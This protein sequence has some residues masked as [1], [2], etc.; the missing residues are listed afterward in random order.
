MTEYGLH[1]SLW[2][3]IR[4]F[5]SGMVEIPI[6]DCKGVVLG[7]GIVSRYMSTIFLDD[8]INFKE[9]SL[10]RLMGSTK[11]VFISP[12]LNLISY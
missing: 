2:R 9:M 7:K 12:T 8:K 1:P 3:K 6:R 11:E 5:H 4:N 10:H